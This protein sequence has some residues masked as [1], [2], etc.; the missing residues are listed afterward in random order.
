MVKQ[1]EENEIY[2]CAKCACVIDDKK[3]GMPALMA[4]CDVPNIPLPTWDLKICFSC[5]RELLKSFKLAPNKLPADLVFKSLLCG[6]KGPGGVF[7]EE[8]PQSETSQR[9]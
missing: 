9:R 6:L 8:E 4:G 7:D 3:Q 1:N 5:T 2:H